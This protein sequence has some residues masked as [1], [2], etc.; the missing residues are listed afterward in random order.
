MDIQKM[1]DSR[2]LINEMNYGIEPID[3]GYANRTL[4]INVGDG[5]IQEKPVTQLMKD[6]FVGGKGFGLYFLWDAVTPETK[7][8]SPENEI[9][10]AGGPICGITQYPGAGKALVC[11]ISPLTGIP[12]DSNVG[13]YFGPLLKFSG[14][15][16]L[17]IQG[18]ADKDVIVFIDGN[19]GIVRI[20]EADRKSVV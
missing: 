5:S 19:K 18:K 8:N 15:D 17:E 10:I 20:E 7:W 3:K 6:K 11:T 16:A 1:K 9:I 14:W 12:I 4:Y 2:V 13:G